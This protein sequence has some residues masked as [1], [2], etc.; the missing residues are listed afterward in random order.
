ML[1]TRSVIERMR[2]LE[3]AARSRR[4]A[5]AFWKRATSGATVSG[6]DATGARVRSLHCDGAGA[7]TWN[8]DDESG[9]PLAGVEQV[10]GDHRV[11]RKRGNNYSV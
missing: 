3:A 9:R 2:F 1:L 10:T 4:G 11:E 5:G 8:L 7:A 6:T